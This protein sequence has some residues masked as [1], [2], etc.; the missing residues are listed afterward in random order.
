MS[1]N[2]EARSL[3]SG[4]V[5]PGHSSRYDFSIEGP[6]AALLIIDIQDY[7]SRPA[8]PSTDN[9][10]NA[11]GSTDQY[12]FHKSLPSAIKNVEILLSSFRQT[13]HG[14]ESGKPEIIFTYLEAVTEDCRDVSMDYK[15][16]GPK[17]SV[18]LPTPTKPAILLPNVSPIVNEI[19]IPK[20]S[21]SVFLSTNINYIL[22][23]L[24][25]EQLVICGQVTNQCVESA[26]RD[27]ADLGYFVTVVH[28]ACAAHSLQG[29]QL[30]LSN[31]KGFARILSTEQVVQELFLNNTFN[32]TA[33]IGAKDQAVHENQRTI[34]NT[35]KTLAFSD[36]CAIPG[37]VPI[38][39]QTIKSILLTL[40]AAQVQFLRYT[41]LDCTNGIRCKAVPL[42]RLIPKPDTIHTQVCIAEVCFGGMPGFCDMILKDSGLSARN[43]LVLRP[44]LSTCTQIHLSLFLFILLLSVQN[45]HDFVSF[46]R[47]ILVLIDSLR[48]L[49]YSPSSALV[50]CT[51]HNQITGVVSPFCTRSLLKKVVDTA[52]ESFGISFSVGVELEF[53][54]ARKCNPLEPVD[55][56]V[57]ANTITLDEQESFLVTLHKWLTMLDIPIS[58]IHSESAPGQLE[59]VLAH[60]NDAL[61]MADQVIL[62]KE[63]SH[64]VHNILSFDTP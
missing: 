13:R 62:A 4:R 40:R 52:L 16:S 60:Q 37:V 21:C 55:Y 18:Q 10:T 11:E 38:H 22:K 43:V 26:C 5:L 47:P 57:F 58:Q 54:L 7:L 14:T 30:G 50:M 49:P 33:S 19:R 53:I 3:L 36:A 46:F 32:N 35:G 9:S 27:A 24:N 31:M 29:H 25:V 64:M 44:D 20:T 59:V 45:P 12:L 41:A 61:Q 34:G 42:P 1:V 23:N 51:L 63:V 8:E 28:D 48:I 15:L 17:L 56:S 6:R 2:K 39:H